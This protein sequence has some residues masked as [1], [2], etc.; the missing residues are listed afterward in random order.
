M[1]QRD[2]VARGRSKKPVPPTKLKLP[3]LRIVITIS[4]VAGFSYFL[5]SIKGAAPTQ[6]QIETTETLPNKGQSDTL[7]EIPEEEWE[8]I[9][10]LPEFTVEIEDKQQGQPT[11]RRLMQCGSF[12]KNAQAQQLKAQI[13]FQGLEAMV[14]SSQGSSG[15]W[16]RVI[17]GPYASKR[18]AEKD[19][20]SL[21]RA[22]INGCKIWNWNL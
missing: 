14:K 22:K 1:A 11:V 18:L 20:H 3:W 12:R 2:Y 16:Y 21:Q 4:L 17:L 5:W 8:F 13:A 15:I 7:P 19:R 10:S 6:E 9:K